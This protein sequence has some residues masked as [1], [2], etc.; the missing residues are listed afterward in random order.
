MIYQ[1]QCARE[2]LKEKFTA[3]SC[4]AELI[5]SFSYSSSYHVLG[6]MASSSQFSSCPFKGCL[7]D[8]FPLGQ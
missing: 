4:H 5:S 6:Q 2:T 7:I 1:T 3:D 8:P